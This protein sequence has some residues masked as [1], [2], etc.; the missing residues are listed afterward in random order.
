MA[1]G[2][3]IQNDPGQTLGRLTSNIYVVFDTKELDLDQRPLRCRA[4]DVLIVHSR[5]HIRIGFYLGV[6]E[7]SLAGMPEWAEKNR[8]HRLLPARPRQSGSIA[9]IRQMAASCPTGRVQRG[10]RLSDR[11]A[12]IRNASQFLE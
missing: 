7:G 10:S 12:F 6:S 11:Y 2:S 4:R 8:A 1:R 3:A 9:A 5:L